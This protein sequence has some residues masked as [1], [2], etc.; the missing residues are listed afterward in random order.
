LGIA[1]DGA[2]PELSA[3]SAYADPSVSFMILLSGDPPPRN[4]GFVV[5]LFLCVLT[6]VL[7]VLYP[8]RSII[9]L[10]RGVFS[11]PIRG[12]G[13]ELWG[14]RFLLYL[15]GWTRTLVLAIFFLRGLVTL[16]VSPRFHP[17]G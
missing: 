17:T 3:L 9:N 5:S 4:P 8:P 2:G 10:V 6:N 15:R 13:P 1:S 7:C 12:H 16:S 11:S 14:A